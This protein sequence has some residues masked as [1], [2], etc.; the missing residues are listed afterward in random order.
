MSDLNNKKQLKIEGMIIGGSVFGFIF[1]L[2]TYFSIFFS[3]A[4][5]VVISLICILISIYSFAI[6]T[7]ENRTSEEQ[8][9]DEF[10]RGADISDQ[11]K[12]Y[13]SCGE[14]I[15]TRIKDLY[16]PENTDN[17]VMVI[18]MPD[19]DYTFN[20]EYPYTW[21]SDSYLVQTA[22][23]RGYGPED[24]HR[25]IGDP[26]LAK[27]KDDGNQRVCNYMT[28]S[29]KE[30]IKEKYDSGEINRE[31]IDVRLIES[32]F[33]IYLPEFQDERSNTEYQKETQEIEN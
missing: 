9:R 12:E 10:V 14:Y 27:I 18:E 8:F 2:I 24:F 13:A 31:D 6:W 25:L 1:M 17:I 22:N 32:K 7:E 16:S 29:V 5:G 4:S 28:A 19:G 3:I 21:D 30:K 15:V 20:Y 11:Y 23:N 33:D 26:V